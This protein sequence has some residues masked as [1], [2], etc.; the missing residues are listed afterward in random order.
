MGRVE[1]P[2]GAWSFRD[3]V[4]YLIDWA[5]RMLD[6]FEPPTLQQL[7]PPQQRRLAEAV[8]PTLRGARSDR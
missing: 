3:F 5:N 7:Q 8:Q 4:A 6:V 1:G 2:D